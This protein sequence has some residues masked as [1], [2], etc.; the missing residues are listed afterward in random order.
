MSIVYAEPKLLKIV[1]SLRD[2][3]LERSRTTA[4]RLATEL[5]GNP[6]R[7]QRAQFRRVRVV[8]DDANQ[9]A[10]ASCHATISTIGHRRARSPT[11]V[12]AGKRPAAII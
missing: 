11:R 9:R 2:A 10:S 3:S 4:L 5:D 1:D 6:V 8:T 12:P 7:R